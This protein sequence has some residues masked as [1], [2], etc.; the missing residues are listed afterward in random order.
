VANKEV[1]FATMKMPVISLLGLGL[2]LLMSGCCTDEQ[3][4][5]C[6]EMGIVIHEENQE[7]YKSNELDR[8]AYFDAGCLQCDLEERL[9]CAEDAYGLETYGLI[10]Y[11]AEARENNIQGRVIIGFVV[12]KDGSVSN[13][14]VV[15]RIGYGCDEEVIEVIKAIEPWIPAVKDGTYVR[16]YRELPVTFKLG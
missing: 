13:F 7:V 6:D 11:P 3:Y 1:Y 12:E 4:A 5:I 14:E 15:E 10:R 2:L 8:V 16:S 9:E